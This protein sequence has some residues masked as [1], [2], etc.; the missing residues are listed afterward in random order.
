MLH[1]DGD[2]YGGAN[3]NVVMSDNCQCRAYQD[4][5]DVV[6]TLYNPANKCE[7]YKVA[8]R[9]QTTRVSNPRHNEISYS[10]T[11]RSCQLINFELYPREPTS[12]K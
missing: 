10:A 5:V 12:I 4:K 8:L 6:S 1:I 3:T 7:A 9:L 11:C 2:M